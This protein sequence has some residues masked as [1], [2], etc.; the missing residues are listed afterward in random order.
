MTTSRIFPGILYAKSL[1]PGDSLEE[2]Y[3]TWFSNA[4]L[5]DLRD[6]VEALRTSFRWRPDSSRRYPPVMVFE[7][8]EGE[9]ILVVRFSDAGKD[10][11]G[12]PQTLRMEALLVPV[13]L[14]SQFWDGTFTAEPD[15]DHAAFV[16]DGTSP[17]TDFPGWNQDRLVQGESGTF[18]LS[19]P[20]PC[21]LSHVATSTGHYNPT[22]V[23]EPP[24]PEPTLNP[25]PKQQSTSES[26]RTIRL[27]R[28]VGY[29]KKVEKI[30]CRMLFA[31]LIV[32]FVLGGW[33]YFQSTDEIERLRNSLKTRDMEIANHRVEIEDLHKENGRLQSE[34]SKFETW[35]KTRSNFELNKVQLK[36]KFAEIIKD[37]RD[38]EILLAHIDETPNLTSEKGQG[39]VP[40]NASG[41][42]SKTNNVPTSVDASLPQRDDSKS[43]GTAAVSP[44]RKQSKIEDKK[45]G[46]WIGKINLFSKE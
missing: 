6:R 24:F 44:E 27:E 35:I 11:F 23:Q 12:R 3:K 15:S 5:G 21:S 10:P 39:G 30:M 7:A 37:F 43:T 26:R 1:R 36:I 31:L 8:G 16:V 46:G 19:T 45:K 18:S 9:R 29:P 41:V 38:A 2:G 25:P 42:I 20:S 28:T 17:A 22:D 34:I 32:S 40:S 33:N 14:A 13:N 4:E